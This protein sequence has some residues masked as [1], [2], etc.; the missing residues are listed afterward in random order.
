[1]VME[2]VSHTR[3]KKIMADT[4]YAAVERGIKA[5]EVLPS[6]PK[7]AFHLRLWHDYSAHLSR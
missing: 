5:E 6:S 1:M 2:M 7:S 4:L 3:K